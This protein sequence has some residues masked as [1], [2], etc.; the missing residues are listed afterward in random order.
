[1]V[2]YVVIC[3][4]AGRERKIMQEWK[5]G[6]VCVWGDTLVLDWKSREGPSENMTSLV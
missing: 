1:M 4:A 2:W 3:A 6:G 5:I